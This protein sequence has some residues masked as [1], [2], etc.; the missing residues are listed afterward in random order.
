MLMLLL[1][2]PQVLPTQCS[3]AIA[4]AA[5]WRAGVATAAVPGL[6]NPARLVVPVAR[7]TLPRIGACCVRGSGFAR[8]LAG[9][10]V[11]PGTN[12]RPL[13]KGEP[14]SL[15]AVSQE[16]ATRH[17]SN[18]VSSCSASGISAQSTTSEATGDPSQEQAER[19]GMVFEQLI[20]FIFQMVST[21]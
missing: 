19:S 7:L 11:W 14:W 18:H 15:H 3:M 9:K 5:T 21:E 6:T 20:L 2:T 10:P 13:R 16:I 1:P 8:T 17:R 4:M 12:R